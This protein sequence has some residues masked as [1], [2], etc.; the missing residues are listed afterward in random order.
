MSITAVLADG[1]APRINRV[2][3][4]NVPTT[5]MTLRTVVV[6]VESVVQVRSVVAVSVLTLSLPRHIVENAGPPVVQARP[7][8]MEFVP[9]SQPRPATVAC[10]AKLV[11]RAKVVAT[12]DASTSTRRPHTAKPVEMPALSVVK[13]G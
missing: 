13:Q 3:M 10:V 11:A 8:V 12:V 9:L 1:N 7:V 2:A 4:A 6:V 5:R